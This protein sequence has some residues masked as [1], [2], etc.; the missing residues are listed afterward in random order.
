MVLFLE[1]GIFQLLRKNCSNLHIVFGIL[2]LQKAFFLLGFVFYCYYFIDNLPCF[3]YIIMAFLESLF[4]IILFA[5]FF[6]VGML[7]SVNFLF[8][9]NIWV[10]CSRLLSV[11]GILFCNGS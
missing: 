10:V 2:S 8:S 6:S 5:D 7:I 3:F 9:N 4:I 11:E 1:K